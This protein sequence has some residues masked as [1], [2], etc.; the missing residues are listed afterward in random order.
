[1]DRESINSKTFVPC[2]IRSLCGAVFFVLLFE[3]PRKWI[4]RTFY[5]FLKYEV[6]LYGR[7]ASANTTGK[8]LLNSS[9]TL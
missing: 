6:V 7:N 1:M 4:I 2:F 9:Q 3:S 5:L 8:R